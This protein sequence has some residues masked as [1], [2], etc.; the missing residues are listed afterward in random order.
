MIVAVGVLFSSCLGRFDSLI[1]DGKYK[2][3]EGVLEQMKGE[4]REKCA[5][6]LIKEYLD[7]EEY[8][9]A[10]EVYSNICKGSSKELLR[11]A[12]TVLRM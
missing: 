1:V 3:A 10:Y 12:F 6:I 9:K 7:L 11:K 5:D 8:D 4:N 2:E